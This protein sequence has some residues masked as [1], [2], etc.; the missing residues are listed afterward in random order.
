MKCRQ[1]PSERL[2]SAPSATTNSWLQGPRIAR[3]VPTPRYD[4]RCIRGVCRPR[5]QVSR[6]TRIP[7][8]AQAPP[9]RPGPTLQTLPRPR[10]GRMTRA[11]VGD[12]AGTLPPAASF[13]STSDP[14][15]RRP[16]AAACSLA[17]P[18]PHRGA[19]DPRAPHRPAPRPGLTSLLRSAVQLGVGGLR[20]ILVAC[21]PHQ[22]ILLL[23]VAA[24]L[25]LRLRLAQHLAHHAHA[26]LR[27]PAWAEW[28]A[29]P[30][31]RSW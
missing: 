12:P 18:L 2:T 9:Q 16:P 20:S 25:T 8:A 29:A 10:R 3:P 31:G 30:R 1:P 24:V 27:G 14:T 21:Q 23:V 5:T 11:A 22:L 4:T 26:C 13:S 19:R 15:P 6:E 28:P 7:P 17:A